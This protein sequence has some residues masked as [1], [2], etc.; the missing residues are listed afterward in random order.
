MIKKLVA[1]ITI[2]LLSLSVFISLVYAENVAD[3]VVKLEETEISINDNIIINFYL[4]KIEYSNFII[5]IASSKLINNVEIND[6]ENYDSVNGNQIDSNSSIAENINIESDDY[7]TEILIN[8]NDL[9]LDVLTLNYTINDDLNIGDKVNFD[10]VIINAENDDESMNYTLTATIVDSATNT[11]EEN[12]LNEN[13]Q[14]SNEFA[15]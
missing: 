11:S 8:K 12:T 14:V 1:V 3:S 5:Q 4:N 7:T 2:M 13:T 6:N 9:N 15:R 10:I